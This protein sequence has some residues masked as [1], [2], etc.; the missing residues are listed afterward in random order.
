MFVVSG[1]SF[2]P[3]RIAIA[4]V[5]CANIFLP[6]K[7]RIFL[8]FYFSSTLSIRFLF[9]LRLLPDIIIIIRIYV[10]CITLYLRPYLRINYQNVRSPNNYSADVVRILCENSENGYPRVISIRYTYNIIPPMQGFEQTKKKIKKC[11]PSAD[12]DGS[13]RYRNNR[14]PLFLIKISPEGFKGTKS[15]TKRKI[16]KKSD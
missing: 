10:N 13:T 4:V 15:K 2:F 6:L 12:R 1:F 16:K 11:E 3:G 14:K 5:G 9:I 7:F 8:V